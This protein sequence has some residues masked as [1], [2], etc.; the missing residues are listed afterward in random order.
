MGN[1]NGE[2]KRKGFLPLTNFTNSEQTNK[3]H[4]KVSICFNFVN[5]QH[6]A[7]CGVCS[8][9]V[10]QGNGVEATFSIGTRMGQAA[11]CSVRALHSRRWGDHWSTLALT[12]PYLQSHAPPTPA[13]ISTN[14]G[15]S[16]S[17]GG[18][19]QC[20]AHGRSI[21]TDTWSIQ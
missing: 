13:L 12:G 11:K 18:R 16:S 3:E 4:K 7:I 20:T 15:R 5:L 10:M 6:V 9:D 19:D 2:N 14:F 21:V 1:A 8:I 17:C